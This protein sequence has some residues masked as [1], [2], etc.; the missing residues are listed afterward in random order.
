MAATILTHEKW[1]LFE[2]GIILF[3]LSQHFYNMR[4]RSGFS[5]DIFF[6]KSM[7]L[8]ISEESMEVFG[9]VLTSD[10]PKKTMN[11]CE[12]HFSWFS[13]TFYIENMQTR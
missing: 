8:K 2:V 1:L 7:N 11:G 13:F 3:L 4:S 9:M 6:A 5:R 12:E 10:M